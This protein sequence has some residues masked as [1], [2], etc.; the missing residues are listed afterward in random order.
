MN[1]LEQ[2]HDIEGLD[3][4]SMWPLAIGWWLLIGLGVLAL[5]LLV[6]FIFKRI[7]FVRSWK[8]DT[9][10]KLAHLEKNLSEATSRETVVLLSEYVRRIAL[11]VHSRDECAGLSGESWLKW[12]KAN[13]PMEFDWEKKGTVL[14]D[15]PYAPATKELQTSEIKE[16]IRATRKWVR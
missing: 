5:T 12:L 3:P 14:I 15:A 9:F 8:Y 7:L 4:I 6:F 16:L 10:K 1:L 2:L 11:K 13:D